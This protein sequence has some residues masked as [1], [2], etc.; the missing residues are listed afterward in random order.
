MRTWHLCKILFLF[1]D[2]SCAFLCPPGENRPTNLPKGSKCGGTCQIFG[3]CAPGF[4]C[5][6][7]CEAER[8]AFIAVMGTTPAGICKKKKDCKSSRTAGFRSDSQVGTLT[9]TE[10]LRSGT[11]TKLESVDDVSNPHTNSSNQNST[12]VILLVALLISAS[13]F[14]FFRQ[15]SMHK[16]YTNLGKFIT[17]NNDMPNHEAYDVDVEIGQLYQH[18]NASQAHLSPNDPA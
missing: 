11:A 12:I 13:L 10:A 5:I 8:N 16:A 7:P 2:F 9:T 18:P 17:P 4:K 15:Q 6:T 1:V 14:Y 3:I